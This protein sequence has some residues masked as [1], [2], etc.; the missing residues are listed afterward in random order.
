MGEDVDLSARARVRDGNDLYRNLTW[1]IKS[2][3]PSERPTYVS[4]S[5]SHCVPLP[6]AGAPAMMILGVAAR[7]AAVM[8][9]PLRREEGEEKEG[10]AALRARESLAT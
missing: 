1:E 5:S 2:C 4:L 3:I 7:A 10:E 6:E 9:R 8:R